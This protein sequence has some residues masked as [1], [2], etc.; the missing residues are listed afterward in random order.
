MNSR[1][2]LVVSLVAIV[3]SGCVNRAAQEQAKKT[4]EIVTDPKKS[5]SVAKSKTMTLRETLEITGEVTTSNDT[6][7]GA[8]VSGRVI[9]V[10]VKDGDTVGAGQLI[11]ELDGVNQRIQV[12]QA[13]SQV[14]ASRA[15]LSQAQAN[16]TVGPQR[17]SAAVAQAQAQLRSAKS[18]LQK[19]L[20]GARPEERVQAAAAVQSARSNAETA[21][22]ELERV[23]T[24][25]NQQVVSQ[26]RLDQAENAFNTAAAQLQQAEAALSLQQNWTRPEDI[27]SARESVRQAEEGV[28]TAQAGKKLDILLGQ[29]VMAAQANLQGAQASL[30]LAR[31]ALSDLIIRAPFAGQVYGKPV[32][33]GSV[34]GPGSPV[35][36]LVGSEG[37]YFEGEFP[38]TILSKIRIGSAV[39]VTV[40]GYAGSGLIGSIT[41]VSPSASS[42]GRLFKA[43]VQIPFRTEI[44]PGMFARG[45]VTMRTVPDASVVPTQAITKRGSKSVVFVIQGTKAKEVVVT[46]GLSADGY[47]QVSAILPG[48]D[49]VVNGQS[50]LENGSDVTVETGK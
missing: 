30:A 39:N 20:N 14:A 24:L 28:R 19:A 29:Q 4:Q 37:A 48:E 11:A 44:K 47:T 5:V 25:F 45:A 26:Q 50:D 42:V 40:E 36:R 3:G 33:P 43:R 16:A 38:A 6:Q 10:Y 34:V 35:V 22:K 15:T 17:T 1:T 32:Q 49:V 12:Q 46:P 41:S 27:S 7:V 31:Q 21:K 23:R 9:S 13:L 18:Q 8:K 2:I